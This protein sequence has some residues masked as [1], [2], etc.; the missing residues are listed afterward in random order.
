MLSI[1]Y[2]DPNWYTF[3][4]KKR[5]HQEYVIDGTIRHMKGEFDMFQ[6][7]GKVNLGIVIFS[8]QAS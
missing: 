7:L 8:N 3:P 2:W 1:A 4:L 5:W 6:L